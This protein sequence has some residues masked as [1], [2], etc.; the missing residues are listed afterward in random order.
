MSGQKSS[1][2]TPAIGVGIATG[3][4]YAFSPLTV[5]CL[6]GF[7]ALVYWARRGLDGDERRWLTVILV[8]AIVTRVL[9]VAGLFLF[10]DHGRVPFGSFFG[11][12][13]YFIKRSIRSTRPH[14]GIR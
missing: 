14:G 3:L 9:A 11:D 7:A 2:W 6:A 5:I 10:T 13:E 1:G 8:V 12:E 4:V